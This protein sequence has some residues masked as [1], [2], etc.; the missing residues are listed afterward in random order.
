MRRSRSGCA[1][2]V[3]CCEKP[4][5]RATRTPPLSHLDHRSNEKTHHV[6]KKT[7]R[8]NFEHPAAVALDPPRMPN[9]AAVVVIGR[10]CVSDGKRTERVLAQQAVGFTL[11]CS[12]IERVFDRPFIPST[13]RG[14][15]GIIRSNKITVSTRDGAPSRMKLGNHPM[16]FRYPDIIGKNGVHGP[17]KS[18][19]VPSGRHPHADPLT[20]R[21]NARV[22]SPGTEGRYGGFAQTRKGDFHVALYGADDGLTLPAGEAPPVILRYQE[23]R[24]RV[25][26]R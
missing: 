7:V 14:T 3:R 24:S 10:R 2:I 12:R 25:H 5:D 11:Q 18:G 4:R 6:M 20:V 21:V 23:D 17:T 9:D 15:G 13:E 1:R 22:G 26:D 19:R 8:R 16:R